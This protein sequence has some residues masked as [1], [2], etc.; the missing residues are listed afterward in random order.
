MCVECIDFAKDELEKVGLQSI[1]ST[2]YVVIWNTDCLLFL[3]CLQSKEVLRTKLIYLP[4]NQSY[5]LSH[6]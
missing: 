6:L 3:K 2:L 1:I 5:A 4:T